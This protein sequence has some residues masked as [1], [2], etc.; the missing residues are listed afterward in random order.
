MKIALLTSGGD[1]PGMNA[2]IRAVVRSALNSGFEVFGIKYGYKGLLDGDIH[3]MDHDSVSGFL[4]KG[5]TELG[6]ARSME[7]MDPEYKKKGAKIL[8]DLGIDYLVAIG[9]EGTAK[10]ARDLAK[11]GIKVV[12][13]PA[14]IDN[15]YFGTDYS[16]GFNTA[17][18]TITDAVD[19]IRDT[20]SSHRRCS[21]I[22]VMGRNQG[23][24]AIY[25]GI[26]C[27]AEIVITGDTKFD[28]DELLKTISTWHKNARKHV[29]I[30]ITEK[31]V[32]VHELAKE[33]TEKTGFD[34]RATILGH[35]QR[36]GAPSPSDRI[37][38]TKLGEYAVKLL[39]NK[40]FNKSVGIINNKLIS[41]DIDDAL[42]G[43]KDL[44]AYFDLLKQTS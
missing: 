43:K 10:G 11:F 22:E 20:S 14:T 1:A 32:D 27:G 34:T 31:I 33:I 44:K 4:T 13:I 6:S 5:G 36:G 39:K 17:L 40:E 16:I 38:A 18:T 3:K 7:F 41:M 12:V 8:K 42:N 37:L 9:G 24:L 2:A 15:D 21:I 19:K 26:C 35:I 25:S 28:K 30:I 23:D 29:I